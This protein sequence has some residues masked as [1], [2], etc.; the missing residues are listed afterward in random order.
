VQG[1]SCR[2][3]LRGEAVN[4]RSAALTENDDD[5]AAVRLRTLTTADWKL[6]V[7]LSETTGELID[8]VNDPQE[9]RNLWDSPQHAAVKQ[10]LLNQL[11]VATLA[12]IDMLNGRRQQPSAPVPKWRQVIL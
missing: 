4:R 1:V 10:R 6:T 5:F 11:L 9:M 12:S 7:Y 2:D 8:R 3:L